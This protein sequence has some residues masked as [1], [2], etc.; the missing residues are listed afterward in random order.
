MKF[1]IL[2]R[3]TIIVGI[4]CLTGCSSIPDYYGERDSS[5]EVCAPRE[6]IVLAVIE[7][8]DMLG[9]REITRDKTDSKFLGRRSFIAGFLCG[10]GGEDIKV[11]ILELDSKK[12][13]YRINVLSLK[14][15][16]YYVAPDF[17]DKQFMSYFFFVLKDNRKKLNVNE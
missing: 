1:K 2:G 15:V 13:L 8:L 4:A 16:P 17:R 7:A 3:I 14:R 6:N 5:R 10:S 9:C 12:N 11:E